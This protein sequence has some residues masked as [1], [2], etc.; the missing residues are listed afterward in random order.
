MLKLRISKES[1]TPL[2]VLCIGAHSDDLEI[3][4]GGTILAW[5][6]DHPA[7]TITWVVM[8]ALTERNK[9]AHRSAKALL[10][11]ARRTEIVVGDFK[12]GYLNAQYA[13]VKDFFEKL[14][15]RVNPDVVL[16]HWLE[17]RH[18]DHR[19]VSELTWNTWRNQM[20]LEYE[21]PKYEGDLKP[22][23]F[24]V[25]IPA[26]VARRKVAHLKRHFASQR[27]K[28]WFNSATFEAI[29]HLRGLECRSASGLAEAFHARKLLM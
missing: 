23:N 24:Y 14:K 29:M 27:S 17:D 4:C 22:T 10:R 6:A 13:E 26:S 28:D 20:I 18:Q 15:L 3:G 12:D 19:L 5:L 7:V 25:E 2:H 8:T 9:E 1:K 11:K 21:I 16:T